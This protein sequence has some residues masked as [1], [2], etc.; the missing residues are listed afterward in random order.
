MSILCIHNKSSIVRN[1]FHAC[2]ATTATAAAAATDNEPATGSTE[3]DKGGDLSYRA[4]CAERPGGRR[5]RWRPALASTSTWRLGWQGRSEVY[6]PQRWALKQPPQPQKKYTILSTSQPPSPLLSVTKVI[7]E[8][9]YF[10]NVFFYLPLQA[11]SL[12]LS[13]SVS[14]FGSECISWLCASMRSKPVGF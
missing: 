11:A 12:F 7:F 14:L 1:G 8:F 3:L 9:S 13:V 5:R 4:L 2:F 6:Q 10:L